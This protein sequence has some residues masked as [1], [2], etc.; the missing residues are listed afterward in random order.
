M[1]GCQRTLQ[2]I[3]E[4]QYNTEYIPNTEIIRKHHQLV[5]KYH[6][7]YVRKPLEESGGIPPTHLATWGFKIAP[8]CFSYFLTSFFHMFTADDFRFKRPICIRA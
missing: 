7:I 5:D 6:K 3:A 1:P 2:Q 8:F 4:N